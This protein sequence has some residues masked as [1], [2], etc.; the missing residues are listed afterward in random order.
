MLRI[1]RIAGAIKES[2]K[3]GKCLIPRPPRERG[4]LGPSNR[5]NRTMPEEVPRQTFKRIVIRDCPPKR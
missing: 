5:M 1:G 4:D 3:V 2:L